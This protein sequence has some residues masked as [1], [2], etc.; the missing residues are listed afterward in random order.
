V[1]D[2]TGSVMTRVC[3]ASDLAAD[4]S[5]RVVSN[6]CAALVAMVDGA[7]FAIEDRCPHRSGVLS[8]GLLRDGVVTCPEHW[9]RFDV[10]TGARTDHP[11]QSLTR[12]PARVVGGWIEVAFPTT[13]PPLLSIREVLLAHARAGVTP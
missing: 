4:V 12:Y 9:W 2:H 8:E 11:E 10:R 1:S 3:R 13:P 5:L 7:P 6:E